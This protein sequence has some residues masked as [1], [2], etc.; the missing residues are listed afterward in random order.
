M[1][2]VPIVSCLAFLVLPSSLSPLPVSA[3][4]LKNV[5][6]LEQLAHMEDA[7][8]HQKLYAPPYQCR[9]PPCNPGRVLHRAKRTID[10]FPFSL[11]KVT[12]I[13]PGSQAKNGKSVCLSGMNLSFHLLVFSESSFYKLIVRYPFLGPKC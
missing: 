4:Y 10:V 8:Q 7:D 13:V 6:H 12:V 5:D 3:T 1:L 11:L 2:V 9:A